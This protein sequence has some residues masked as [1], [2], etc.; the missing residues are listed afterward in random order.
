MNSE[1]HRIE[2]LTGQKPQED[3]IKLTDH[4]STKHWSSLY[5][6]LLFSEKEKKMALSLKNDDETAQKKV[7]LCI[8]SNIQTI[9]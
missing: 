8:S 7:S 2:F 6:F 3:T 4:M 1:L 9:H 5:G